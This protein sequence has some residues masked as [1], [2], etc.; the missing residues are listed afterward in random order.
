M[1]P[2]TSALLTAALLSMSAS[3]SAECHL[4]KYLDIPVTM[5]GSRAIVSAQINGQDAQFIL[6]SGAFYSDLSPASA[7]TFGLKFT[8]LA[9]QLRGVNGATSASVT[10]VRSF[11]IGGVTIPRIEFIVGGTDTGTA[12]LL[13]QNVLGVGDVDYDF[14]HG[15]VRLLRSTGCQAEQLAYWASDY[16]VTMIPLEHRSFQQRHTI[17]EVTLNGVKLRAL[18]DTG[19]PTT[20]LTLSAAKR[21]GI[22][23]T[24]PGVVATGLSAGLGTRV[25]RSWTATFNQLQIGGESIPRPKLRLSE[26]ELNDADM[27]IGADFFLT[28]HVYVANDLAKMI[29]TYEGGPVF[30]INPSGA[31]DAQG[32][33]LDLTDRSAAP[34]DAEGFAR[35]G[36]VSASSGNQQAAIADFDRAIALDPKQGRYLRQRAAARLANHQP[37]LAASDLD[38]AIALNPADVEARM[39]RGSMRLAAH[40]SAG[41][42]EDI[43]AL[44]KDLAPSAGERL[45][46]AVMAENAGQ[47]DLALTSADDWLKAHP[48]DVERPM[49]LNGRCWILA[50]LNRDL[51][52]AMDDCNAALRASPKSAAFLDSRGLVRI[53][54]GDLRGALKDYDTALAVQ[55]RNAWTL[56]MRGLVKLRTGDAAGADADRKAAIAI[57]PSVR[58]RAAKLGLE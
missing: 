25:V 58:E 56:Y 18:F 15:V 17:G 21:V 32:K 6:D 19:S 2:S 29:F 53:R 27:L 9:L 46:L 16:P 1:R 3:A 24:S 38:K 49:A 34:T 41:A 8:P 40:D 14:R 31:N 30:G 4:A 28:H 57:S 23:P 10:T 44:D 11:S 33:P 47:F 37:L 52:K 51:K 55:P 13:G 5:R 36:A 22:T 7:Q 20:V 39:M 43:R 42:T 12:G 48:E 45:R 50:Q 26:I 54:L 35:R